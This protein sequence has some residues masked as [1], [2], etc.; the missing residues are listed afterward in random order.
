MMYVAV[1]TGAEDQRKRDDDEDDEG[2]DLQDC[3]RILEPSE[4]LSSCQHTA[5]TDP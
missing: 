4:S 2:E 1:G 3:C 5:R